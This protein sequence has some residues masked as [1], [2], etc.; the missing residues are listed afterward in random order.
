MLK[1][2]HDIPWY[3]S[4]GTFYLKDRQGDPR[5]LKCGSSCALGRI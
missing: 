5:V 3:P 4:W 1:R 2:E